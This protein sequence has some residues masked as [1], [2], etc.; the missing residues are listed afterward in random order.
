MI[1]L[2][3]LLSRYYVLGKA[4]YRHLLFNPHKFLIES[5]LFFSFTDEETIRKVK[6]I[7]AWLHD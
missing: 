6:H 5:V 1:I 2:A 3:K 7:C 4:L